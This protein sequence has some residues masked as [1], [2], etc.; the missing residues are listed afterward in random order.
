MKVSVATFAASLLLTACHHREKSVQPTT[1]RVSF[2]NQG[3][4]LDSTVEL[5]RIH[6]CQQDAV[7]AFRKAVQRYNSVPLG[8]DMSKFPFADDGFYTFQSTTQLLSA[9]PIKLRDTPHL[10]ELNCIDTVAI[11]TVGRWRIGLRPDDPFG[12]SL[13][14]QTATSGELQCAPATTPREAFTLSS[15]TG[16]LAASEVFIPP[17]AVDTRISLTAAFYN[18]IRLPPL[19]KYKNPA[20]ELMAALRAEWKRQ[21]IT[22]PTNCEVVLCHQAHFDMH[23]CIAVHAGVLFPNNGRYTY[24]EK[25]SGRGPFVRLDSAAKADLLPWLAGKCSK[26]ETGGNARFFVTFNDCSIEELTANE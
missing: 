6:G 7:A 2:L 10:W 9:L 20:W 13:A 1:V 8:F 19:A 26:R 22:F 11:L 5:L 12:V 4:A 16:Y 3:G 25:D 14:G 24:L 21:F 15:P 18:V 17:S 23:A